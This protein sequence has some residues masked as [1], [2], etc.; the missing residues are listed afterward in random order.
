MVT[1]LACTNSRAPTGHLCPADDSRTA[2]TWRRTAP[3]TFIKT[4]DLREPPRSR[5]LLNLP[6]AH[7]DGLARVRAA[8]LF[9]EPG[10]PNA[11]P[12]DRRLTNG[13][14]YPCSSP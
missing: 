12:S 2:R 9:R 3:E 7:Q 11:S 5:E 6:L 10:T 4:I 1:F 14:T 8:P 13:V